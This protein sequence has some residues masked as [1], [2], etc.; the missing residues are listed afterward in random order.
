[1]SFPRKKGR[2]ITRW[3][4]PFTVLQIYRLSAETELLNDISVSLDVD[5]L[6]VIKE[7]A[8]LTYELQQ[9]T[10]CSVVLFVV[11]EVLSKVSD[12]VGK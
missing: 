11:F 4:I 6:E 9:R 1:M 5:F 8:S 7:A 10:T 2:P 12:T 3:N